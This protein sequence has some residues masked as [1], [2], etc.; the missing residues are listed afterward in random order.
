MLTNAQPQ[1]APKGQT[2]PGGGGSFFQPKLSIN[3]PGDVYEQEADAVAERVMR[4]EDSNGSLFFK[5]ALPALQR[6]EDATM[7]ADAAGEVENYVSRLSGGQH[8]PDETRQFFEAKMG[9]DFSEVKIHTNTE[10]ANSARSINAQ[11]YTTGNQIVF[12]NGRYSTVTNE[13]KYLLAHELTHVVQQRHSQTGGGGFQRTPDI[14]RNG[15]PEG[16][17]NSYRLIARFLP[18]ARPVIRRVLAVLRYLGMPISGVALGVKISGTAGDTVQAGAGVD[19]LYFLDI[20]NLEL[21]TDTLAFGE[22]GVGLSLG[23]GGGIIVGIRVSPNAQYGSMSGAYGGHS[24]NFALRLIAGVGFS[25]SPGIFSG[26]EGFLAATFSIGAQAGASASYSYAVSAADALVAIESGMQ[27]IVSGITNGLR[28]FREITEAVGGVGQEMVSTL[29]VRPI[30][31]ARA[32]LMPSNWNLDALPI[33]TRN[34]L[35][36]IG[37]VVNLTGTADQMLAYMSRRLNSFSIQPLLNDMSVDIVQ[38]LH[39]RGD[40]ISNNIAAYFTPSYIGNL[41]VLNFIQTLEEYG[42]LRFIRP[43][44]V[45]AAEMMQTGQAATP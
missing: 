19:S 42:L 27:E 17:T 13:G 12:G 28:S 16:E 33:R 36:V 39:A 7:R 21:T 43:P 41:S 14:Q 4:T 9:Q 15:E 20:A 22:L 18:G 1:S 30:V 32:S 38:A 31:T 3:E 10:A 5:P 37:G 26:Q 11:A 40:V 35:R 24:F 23:T 34:H 45:I 29:F 6:K 44:A 8:L 25:I 2:Q